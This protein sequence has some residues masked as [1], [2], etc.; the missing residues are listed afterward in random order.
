[1]FNQLK[2]PFLVAGTVNAHHSMWVYKTSNSLFNAT[3]EH[4]LIVLI[5]GSPTL[6]PSPDFSPSAIDLTLATPSVASKIKLTV[7]EYT[8]GSDRFPIHF[9]LTKNNLNFNPKFP[10][11]I[12]PNKWAELGINY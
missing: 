4:D 5:D 1:M 3:D 8:L 12:N 10:W 2:E 6:L 7:L 11:K 9:M